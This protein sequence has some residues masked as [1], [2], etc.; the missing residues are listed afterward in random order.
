MR[1]RHE[2]RAVGGLMIHG[3]IVSVGGPRAVARQFN[4][5]VKEEMLKAAEVWWR[6]MLPKHFKVSAVSEYGYKKRTKAHMMRKS[7]RK[8]HQR[9]MEFSGDLK[10]M[11]TR[12]AKITGTRTRVAVRLTGPRYLYMNQGNP[13]QPNMAEELRATTD[14]EARKLIAGAERRVEKRINNLKDRE[15]VTV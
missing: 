13:S 2:G 4:P 3:Q 9:P 8:G 14:A 12:Q 6:R 15:T 7:R 5:I 1:S 10:R 11:V